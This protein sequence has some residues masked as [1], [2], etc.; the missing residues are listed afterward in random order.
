MESELIQTVLV[1]LTVFRTTNNLIIVIDEISSFMN[2]FFH[3]L[4]V[5]IVHN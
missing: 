4:M 2:Y 1:E 3:N 5:S